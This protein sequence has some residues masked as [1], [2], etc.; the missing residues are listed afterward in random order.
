MT[1]SALAS[2]PDILEDDLDIV[3]VGINPGVYS[4]EKKHY[5]A[6][7]TNLFWPMLYQS[8]LIPTL[9]KPE[10]DWKLTRF[11]MGLTDS[12]KRVTKSASDLS[13]ED[14][15]EGG[16]ILSRKIKYYSP[17]IVC[18]NGLTAYGALFGQCD[19]PGPKKM[20]IGT[21]RLFV[22]PSTS[23]RNASYQKDK[24]LHWF[25]QLRRFREKPL[26]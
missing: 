19:G 23:R 21:S 4:A 16:E 3:F 9:L 24:I 17:R 14:R 6:H 5:Y 25:T 1:G 8:G 20:I 10:D 18:F 26:I 7:P 11:R 2:L 15:H 12:V 22:I 13:T